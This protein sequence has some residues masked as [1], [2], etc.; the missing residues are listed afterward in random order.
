MLSFGDCEMSQD[1][2]KKLIMVVDD[3]TSISRSLERLLVSKGLWSAAC[4]GSASVALEYLST[5]KVDVIISD[6]RMP[7]MSGSEFL[8]QVRLKFPDIPRIILTGHSDQAATIKA[9]NDAEVFRYLQKPWNNTE[10]V[11]TVQNA[12]DHAANIANTTE[13]GQKLASQKQALE[14][15]N[16]QLAQEAATNKAKLE[17]SLILL[18]QWSDTRQGFRS[19]VIRVLLLMSAIYNQDI[20]QLG[21]QIMA[22]FKKAAIDMGISLSPEAPDAALLCGILSDA[23]NELVAYLAKIEGMGKVC[24]IILDS[25]ENMNATGPRAIRADSLTDEVR[26]LRIVHDYCK[27]NLRFVGSGTIQLAKE[28]YRMYDAKQVETFIQLIKKPGYQE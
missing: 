13:L 8:S 18:K 4:F 10:L 11:N 3:E 7:G 16:T 1:Q 27:F 17:K 25:K 22:L 20:V 9:I 5:N 6:E 23:G 15:I 19:E 28:S 2:E 26:L 21:K 14:N 12:L 24:T